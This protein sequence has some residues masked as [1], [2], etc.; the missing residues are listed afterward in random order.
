M[1]KIDRLHQ[2]RIC[3]AREL[4]KAFYDLLLKWKAIA[5]DRAA[6]EN[7]GWYAKYVQTWFVYKEET[8]VILPED[9]FPAELLKGFIS[10]KAQARFEVM[11]KDMEEDLAS[12]GITEIE[13]IG[14]I[15]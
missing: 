7:M 14:F 5:S 9:I 4:P 2:K 6:V 3:E 10:G 1:A 8:Y 12:I 13:S 11:Q 15:D